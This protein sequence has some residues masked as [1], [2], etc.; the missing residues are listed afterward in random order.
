MKD[1]IAQLTR[2]LQEALGLSISI[3][4]WLES[5]RLPQY[6]RQRYDYV[7]AKLPAAESTY[8]FILVLDDQ[9][10]EQSVSDINKHLARIRDLSGS[11]AV[12][13]RT[14]LSSYNRKRFIERHLPFILPGNQMYLPMLGID[15]REHL[16]KAREQRSCFRP[17]TQVLILHVLLRRHSGRYTPKILAKHLGYSEM[18]LSRAFDQLEAAGIGQQSREGKE[19]LLWFSA[20]RR[21]IWKEA[22]PYLVSPVRQS[23]YT[24]WKQCLDQGYVAGE[25]ALSRATMLAEPKASVVAFSSSEI[26]QLTSDTKLERLD[27]EDLDTCRIE[28]WKYKP[29]KLTKER[30]VDP[31]SLYLSLREEKDE[32]IQSA[33]E[34]LMESMIW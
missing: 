14:S 28:V 8:S 3:Q 31:L 22:L 21:D 32:R 19:R 17:S 9:S 30:F 24:P 29:G 33:L 4:P 27:F 20:E 26:K 12:Y 16:R 25:S 34:E 23:F 6:L 5:Q 13:V 10:R 1:V 7:D 2:Y 18:T 11:E 15:L